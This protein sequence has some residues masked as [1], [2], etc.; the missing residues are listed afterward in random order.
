LFDFGEAVGT[1]LSIAVDVSS[2]TR[3]SRNYHRLL[4]HQWFDI[5]DYYFIGAFVY[6]YFDRAPTL[7]FG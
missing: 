2:Y 7:F 3:F 1:E 4:E 5:V 6:S